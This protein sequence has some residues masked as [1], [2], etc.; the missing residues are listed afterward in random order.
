MAGDDAVSLAGPEQDSRQRINDC[1][2]KRS[3]AGR[4]RPGKHICS[5]ELNY[6]LEFFLNRADN[7]L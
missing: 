1:R 7:R 4:S 5:N 6:L 3:F 2:H